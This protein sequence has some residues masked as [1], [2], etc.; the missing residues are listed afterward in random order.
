MLVNYT[1]LWYVVLGR[2]SMASQSQGI[3]ATVVL[4]NA[5][6]VSHQGIPE[7]PR[8]FEAEMMALGAPTVTG[9][10]GAQCLAML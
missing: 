9:A 1:G 4:A 10:A 3:S 2:E 5:H 7:T 6:V 8:M